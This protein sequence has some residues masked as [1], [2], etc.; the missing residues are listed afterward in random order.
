[1]AG[2]IRYPTV[3][4]RNVG[5]IDLHQVELV[6][7]G[8]PSDW[9]DVEPKRVE[10]LEVNQT[11]TFTLTISVPM[12]A[13]AG[14]YI[15]R[16]LAL[17]NE[18][19]DEKTM[20]IRVFTSIDE[21]IAFELRKLTAELDKVRTEVRQAQE[22]GKD[23]SQVWPLL[24]EIEVQIDLAGQ[25]LDEKRYDDALA[26]INTGWNLIRRVRELLAIAP[27]IRPLIVPV[28]PTWLFLLI[29]ALVITV[30][31]LLIFLRRI[32]AALRR[33]FA[34]RV[35]ELVR[36]KEI[37]T[38][39]EER[40]FLE[41]ER[42]RMKRTLKLLEREHEEGIISHAAYTELRR[43]IEDRLKRTIKRLGEI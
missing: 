37:V 10:L 33:L 43:S 23:V 34:P 38:P 24:D 7:S 4:V 16:L 8:L 17:S 6:L 26:H 5:E 1:M 2:W 25:A 41:E 30:F 9:F 40:R 18:T 42:E 21:L 14:E 12:G 36:V 20:M 22:V 3:E 11:Q 28:I 32:R 19:K 31:I 27:F 13:R 35:P 29:L 15:V 39:K